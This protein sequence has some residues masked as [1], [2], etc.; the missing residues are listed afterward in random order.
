MRKDRPPFSYFQAGISTL[1]AWW[2]VPF[3]VA[4]FWLWYVRVHDW[5][6]TGMHIAFLGVGV[7]SAIH[8]QQLAKAT[9]RGREMGRI[10]LIHLIFIPAAFGAMVL[11]LAGSISFEAVTGKRN[12]LIPITLELVGSRAFVDLR[13][14]DVSEKPPAWTGLREKEKEETALVKG[15]RL[16]G[17]DLRH[18]IAIN[19]FLVKARLFGADLRGANLVNANLQGVSLDGV[20]LKRARFFFANLRGA[21]LRS[22]RNLDRDHVHSACLPDP[23]RAEGDR[24]L[25]VRRFRP[26]RRIH[27]PPRIIPPLSHP[28]DRQTE[29]PPRA[30]LDVRARAHYI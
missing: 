25:P 23:G 21:D 15:A 10:R 4:I 13:D 26:G 28:P 8:F 5:I 14:K 24:L 11:I 30:P 12:D 27:A 1:L 16:E 29:S 9:L 2:A 22:A 17:A 7:I 18:A 19:A 3:T 20:D 6:G